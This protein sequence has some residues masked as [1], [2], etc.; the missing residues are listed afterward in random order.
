MNVVGG[1]G[2]GDVG[3]MVVELWEVGFEKR[4]WAA[5]V[6]VLVRLVLAGSVTDA[7]TVIKANR[8]DQNQYSSTNIRCKG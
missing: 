2:F 6:L 3:K 5:K 8:I 4:A 1:T 7:T